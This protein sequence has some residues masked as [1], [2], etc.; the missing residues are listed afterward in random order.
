MG[1]NVFLQLAF[2]LGLSSF[3]G[4]F[5]NRFKLPLIIAYLL[6]GVILVAFPIFSISHSPVLEF[7]P[8]IGISFLLF[9]IGMELDLGEIKT[10]GKP[11]I[12]SSIGQV[13]ITTICGYIIASLLGFDNVTSMLIGVGLAFSSTIVVIK[14]LLEKKDLNSLYGKLAI[15]ILLVED[16]IAIVV[17]MVIS[18]SSSVLH[19][20]LQN[21]LPLAALLI[22]ITILF[23]STFILSKY[24][25]AK[26]F[27][28]VAKSVE[29]LFLTALTWCFVFTTLATLAGFSVVIGAFLAGLALAQSPYHYQI[30]S[31]IK[32]LRDFFVVL[33]FV[34]L[35]AQVNLA[36]ALNH[37]TAVIILTLFTLFAKPIL[38]LL[39]LGTFGFRKHTLFQTSLNLSQISEFSL[40]VLL[41]GIQVL[42]AEESSLSVLASVGVISIIISSVFF[43][44]S[45]T[46]YRL[47]G[48]FIRL[49]E[50]QT[51]VHFLE[52]KPEIEEMSDH[53][54]IIGAHRMGGPVV[55]FLQKE[56]IDF[57]VIDLNPHLVQE[58]TK[59]HITAFYGDAGDP[60]ILDLVHLDQAKLIISTSQDMNDNEIIL[61]EA[62]H[63]HTKAILVMRA[64]DLEHSKALRDLGAD[65]VITPETLSGDFLVTKIKDSWLKSKLN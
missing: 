47:T 64:L 51:K 16:M 11:I 29:L 9:L 31:R 37:W 21:Q 33:F 23:L 60:E 14:N 12:V 52:L 34:Y 49:F 8:E 39:L 27:S 20:G 40:V 59:E 30:Q 32:P 42:R 26:L 13:I 58:L 38:F 17:L 61:R 19:T 25:L 2:I 28:T 36:Q 54:V 62:K 56:Q 41:V 55:K 15:G 18:V 35:G 7:L 1:D 45:R 43:T 10:L 24:V 3:F 4:I 6:T 22:K 48:P 5:L 46:L 44:F 63:R 57:C 65:F 50:H 53:V